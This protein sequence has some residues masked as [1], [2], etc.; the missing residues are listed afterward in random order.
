MWTRRL[1]SPAAASEAAEDETARTLPGPL[2]AENLG[3]RTSILTIHFKALT[4]S[5]K[6][7]CSGHNT[8]PQG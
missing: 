7:S 6:A 3:L 5:R 1:A 4:T 2:F 8:P